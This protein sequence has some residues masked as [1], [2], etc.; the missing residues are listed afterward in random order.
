VPNCKQCGAPLFSHAAGDTQEYCP[1][2]LSRIRE[3][4]KQAVSASQLIPLIRRFPITTGLIAINIL[5]FVAMVL[6]GVSPTSPTTDQVLPWGADYGPLTLGAEWWRLLSSMFLHFG[7]I[8]LG[9]NM[10]CLWSLGLLAE[11]LFG[12]WTF[13]AIYV[14]TGVGADLLSLSWDPFRTGAGASGAIFGLAG[15]LIT[16]LYFAKL[17]VPRSQLQGIIK[18]VVVFA[19]LNLVIG[20]SVPFIDNMAHL[21]GLVT[22]LAI[23]LAMA[24]VLSRPRDQRQTAK[25]AVVTIAVAVLVVAFL[26]VK[27]VQ[28]HAVFFGH[29]EKL[30]QDQDYPG[31]LAQ[32][33]QAAARKPND[34]RVQELL[35]YAYEVNHD[36][37]NA[38]IAYRRALQLKPDLKFARSRL[39]ELQAGRP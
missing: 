24:P 17:A 5:V 21:G 35:G 27:K 16:G 23:G 12:R 10:W 2:C 4:Q 38:I 14:A 15:A 34:P 6:K 31:A 19:V 22:G 7:V 30:L 32:L 20:L 26:V 8:H 1:D 13:L 29:G 25:L 39:Q 36:P 11:S 37:S 33:K 3:Q 9:L 18:N 28:A